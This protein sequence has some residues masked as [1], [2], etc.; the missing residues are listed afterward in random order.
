MVFIDINLKL[1]ML[2]MSTQLFGSSPEPA[3]R[4][5][6]RKEDLVTTLPLDLLVALSPFIVLGIL[7]LIG[8]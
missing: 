2:Y 7:S 4:Q 6:A 3:D 8:K 1:V 5:T